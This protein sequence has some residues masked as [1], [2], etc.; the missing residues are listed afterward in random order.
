MILIKLRFCWCS[1][2][3]EFFPQIYKSMFENTKK[4]IEDNRV[5]FGL[6]YLISNDYD[7]VLRQ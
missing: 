2:M 3:N 4:L 7:D 1:R 5:L 6:Y